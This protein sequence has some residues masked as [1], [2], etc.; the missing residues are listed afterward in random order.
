RTHQLGPARGGLANSRKT[1]LVR[2]KQWQQLLGVHD[3]SAARNQGQQLRDP[4]SSARCRSRT[5]LSTCCRMLHWS[6]PP[7]GLLREK[8]LSERESSA[9]GCE[10]VMPWAARFAAF[11]PYRRSEP[12][13]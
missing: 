2:S 4:G 10:Q 12:R 11:R 5:C 7:F 9:F 8:A 1:N 13:L 6:L 3:R